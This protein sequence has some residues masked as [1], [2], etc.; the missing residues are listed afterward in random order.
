M[1]WTTN[2][3][4]Y[5]CVSST[6]TLLA[7]L[8]PHICRYKPMWYLYTHCKTDTSA[9][10]LTGVLIQSL[11]SVVSSQQ[12]IISRAGL[13]KT[14]YFKSGWSSRCV[15][16]SQSMRITAVKP[17]NLHPGEYAYIMHMHVSTYI[18]YVIFSIGISL[19]FVFSSYNGKFRSYTQFQANLTF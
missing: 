3:N 17:N 13:T 7:S 8:P 12:R 15:G 11:R 10:Y 9:K 2:S 16:Q 6:Y 18:H 14:G 19:A 4:N 1:S 5:D